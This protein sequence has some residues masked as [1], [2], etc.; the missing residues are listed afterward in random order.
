MGDTAVARGLALAISFLLLGVASGDLAHAIA[1]AEGHGPAP[2]LLT[3]DTPPTAPGSAPSHDAPECPTC[4]GARS[5]TVLLCAG[6]ACTTAVA[7]AS[8]A[9]SLPEAP[10]PAAPRRRADPARAPP[11]RL[12]V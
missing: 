11:A 12:V 7:G 2:A 1:S 3:P 8:L 5:A 6:T 9:V 10:S 4:R